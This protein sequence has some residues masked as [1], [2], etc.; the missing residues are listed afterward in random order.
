MNTFATTHRLGLIGVF[1]VAVM[2]LAT[3]PTVAFGEEIEI[4]LNGDQ[5]VP[6]VKTAATGS[7]NITV[8]SDMSLSGGITTKGINGT[9][10]HIHQGSAGANG[11]V[12]IPFVKNGDNGWMVPAGT[13]MTEAQYQAYK[14]GQ[15]YVNVHSVENKGGE[16]RGQLKP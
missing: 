11:P 4:T 2:S 7:G 6:P 3:F 12:I 8:N 13:K 16:I 5:E 10:A 1:A 14:A 9:M 15:L